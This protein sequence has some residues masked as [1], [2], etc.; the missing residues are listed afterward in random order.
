MRPRAVPARPGPASRE[1]CCRLYGSYAALRD[2]SVACAL[3]ELSGG[4]VQSFSLRTQPRALT[5]QLLQAAA[6]RSSLLVAHGLRAA[7]G[8]RGARAPC[9]AYVLAGMARVRGATLVLRL[10]AP[11]GGPLPGAWAPGSAAWAALAPHDRDLLAPRADSADDF[12]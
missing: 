10:R 11:A 9:R 8:A 7:R 1:H 4:V 5:L 3:Q 12:W 2:V 6:P